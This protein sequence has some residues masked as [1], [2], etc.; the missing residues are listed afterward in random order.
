MISF[1]GGGEFS[2]PIFRFMVI[3]EWDMLEIG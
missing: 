3:R 1:L 2:T